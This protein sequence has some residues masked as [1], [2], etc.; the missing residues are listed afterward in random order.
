[1]QL[2]ATIV[3]ALLGV[4]AVSA[5]KGT[6]YHDTNCKQKGAD[7]DNPYTD[8]PL[9]QGKALGVVATVKTIIW[10]DY[11]CKDYPS[12]WDANKCAHYSNGAEVRCLMKAV[13]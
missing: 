7:F 6:W 13:F 1:M 10:S 8:F 2:L 4:T 9:D 12:T 5:L 11:K 3:A